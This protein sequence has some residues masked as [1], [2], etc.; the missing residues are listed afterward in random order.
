MT[1]GSSDAA[2]RLRNCV[3]LPIL[4]YPTAV[5]G[6]LL[7]AVSRLIHRQCADVLALATNEVVIM[8][9]EN[10]FIEDLPDSLTGNPAR[11]AS[12]VALAKDNPTIEAIGQ[13]GD[14][15]I[16]QAI[17]EEGDDEGPTT[18]AIGEEG[19]EPDEP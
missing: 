7:R 14:D 4:G 16:T 8:F 11:R 15:V 13:E 17:G 19:D 2:Y 10:L 12:S 9:D 5:W 3:E 18:M 1:V 6:T